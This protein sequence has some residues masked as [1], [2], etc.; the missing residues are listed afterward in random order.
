ML[1][2][3]K[4]VIEIVADITLIVISTIAEIIEKKREK[5]NHD[6]KTDK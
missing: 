3:P 4:V 1:K 5:K 2:V 6:D